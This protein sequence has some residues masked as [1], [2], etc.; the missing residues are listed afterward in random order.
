MF[1]HFELCGALCP[2]DCHA[3]APSHFA[4]PGKRRQCSNDVLKL[5]VSAA[6]TAG[7]GA[8]GLGKGLFPCSVPSGTLLTTNK[9]NKSASSPQEQSVCVGERAYS[10]TCYKN[11]ILFQ[12]FMIH[13]LFLTMLHFCFVCFASYLYC[14]FMELWRENNLTVVMMLSDA[15]AFA[16]LHFNTWKVSL[17]SV[18]AFLIYILFAFMSPF[19]K[20]CTC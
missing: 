13:I 4:R 7:G 18:I 2:H 6:L 5:G 19:P 10:K 12:S 11:E 9:I 20:S 1:C 3:G 8:W 14:F 17:E 15:N 16:F